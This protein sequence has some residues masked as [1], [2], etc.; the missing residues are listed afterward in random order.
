MPNRANS[1]HIL[2][3]EHG[4]CAIVWKKR[5]AFQLRNIYRKKIWQLSGIVYDGVWHSY[6]VRRLAVG[7]H[8][9]NATLEDWGKFGQFMIEN[10][11]L[12]DGT[13]ILPDHWGADARK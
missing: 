13:T 1:G 2:P 7:A 6:E 4:F 9:F 3:V 5:W 11:F 12:P 10:G 8:R